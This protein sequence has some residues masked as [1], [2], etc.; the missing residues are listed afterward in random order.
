MEENNKR[1]FRG[2]RTSDEVYKPFKEACNIKGIKLAYQLDRLMI[3]YAEKVRKE[4]EKKNERK[5]RT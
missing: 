2:I 3:E 5:N 4:I 1:K